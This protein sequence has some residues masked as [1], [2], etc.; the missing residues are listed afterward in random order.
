MTE[1]NFKL[2]LCDDSHATTWNDFLLRT[3]HSNFYQRFEWKTLNEQCFGHKTDFLALE[4]SREIQAVLPLVHIN[5][6]LF[7]NVLA[8]M[9]FVNFGGPASRSAAAEQAI[10]AAARQMADERQVDYLE[11]RCDRTL[12]ADMPTATHKISMTIALD[13]NPDTVWNKFK[14]KH[15]TQIRR[16]YKDGLSAKYGEL[17]LLDTFYDLYCESWRALGTPVYRKQYFRSIL[18]AFP[19]ETLIFVVHYRGQPIA[20]A[21]N[22]YYKGTVEGMWAAI[23]PQAR[24]LNPNYVLYWEMI[25]HAC[26][27][28]FRVYHLGRSTAGSTA[29][30]FKSKWNAEPKQL[31]WN[32]H[33]AKAKELP[34][35]NV[36]NPKYQLA[37]KTWRRLPLS[38]T[39]LIGPPLAR[40]I[41]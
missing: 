31:Y 26:E 8:S 34:N 15:R 17:E 7:G 38:V 14:S 12:A 2:V 21:F 3:E 40:C 25:K 28:N 41:P 4:S 30:R 32:Y 27:Q 11:L 6:H 18:E 16:A 36:E 13:S 35:L 24:G 5:S 37:I 20:T 10:V 9:P 1:S 19:K 22:G 23:K 29:E 33:L 39:K